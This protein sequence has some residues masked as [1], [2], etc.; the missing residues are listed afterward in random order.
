[1]SRL[2]KVAR[3]RLGRVRVTFSALPALL[4]SA[5][6]RPVLA[7]GGTLPLVSVV[8]ATY[9]WSN[10]L[11]CAIASVLAQTYPRLEV[12]VVGDCCTDDS[13]DVV[14]SFGDERVRWHNRAEN[15]GSQSLPNNDGI[16]LAR[17]ELV[18]YH[19]H[20]DVWHPTH[21]AHVVQP[22]LQGRADLAYTVTEVVGPPGSGYRV[23]EGLSP[24][25]RFVRGEWV[26]PSSLVHRKSLVEEIG[27]WRDYRTIE[28]P[29]DVDFVLR[30]CEQRK[31]LVPVR[32]LTVFKFASSHRRGSYIEKPSHEQ[33]R[34]LRRIAGERGFLQRELAAIALATLRSLVVSTAARLPQLP[35]PP[36]PLPPGWHV[37]QFRRIRGLD[38]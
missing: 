1:V 25:G 5:R 12:V 7:D 26:A 21:L 32:A 23:L 37:A 2:R 19:G 8:I 22:L 3:A 4:R 9:N 38:A 31:R 27:R 15:S 28:R 34:Y 16:E 6:A 30:A 18:A 10:V 20:D 35:P 29:P 14:A 13:A 36:D 24:S 33:D 17:G 11:R